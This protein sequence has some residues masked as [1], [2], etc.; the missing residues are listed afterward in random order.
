MK[1]IIQPVIIFSLFAFLLS[2]AEDPVEV[3]TGTIKGVVYN[4]DTGDVIG[5]ANI[6]TTP[7]SSAVTSDSATGVFNI[8]HVDTGYHKIE[9]V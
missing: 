2:C 7:P 6:H 4:F 3:T 1:R 8:D 5:Q 9:T